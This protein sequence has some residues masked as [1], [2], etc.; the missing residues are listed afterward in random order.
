M[1]KEKRVRQG[2]LDHMGGE[3]GFKHEWRIENEDADVQN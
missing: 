3:S 1:D 2:M